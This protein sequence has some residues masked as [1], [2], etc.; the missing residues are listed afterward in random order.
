MTTKATA[1][2][3]GIGQVRDRIPA[4]G[5]IAVVRGGALGDLLFDVPALQA[6]ADAYPGAEIVLLGAPGPGQLLLTRPSPV[7]DFMPLPVSPG[8]YEPAGSAYDRK[9]EA[10]FFTVCRERAF[11]LVVQLHGGG[12]WSNPF[13]RRLGG[14]VAVGA[15]A[16]DA[17][18]LDRSVPYRALHH[19]VLRA[20]EVVGLVGAVPTMLEPSIAVTDEDGAAAV[21]ALGPHGHPLLTVH[22]G[23]T[24][25]RRRW[26]PE[27]FSVVAARAVRWGFDVAV[28]GSSGEGALVAEV[29]R[30]TRALLPTSD[31]SAVL[32]LAGSLDIR[33]LVGVLARSALLVGNDSGP[34]HLAQAVGTPTVA[35]FW[36]GNM[37]NAGPF[38][39]A[40]HRP[41]VSWTA[42]C[43]VCGADC[44]DVT[45]ERCA[46]DVSF[47]ADVEV[48]D[49]LSDVEDLL[50]H[51]LRMPSSPP[52]VADWGRGSYSALTG[53]GEAPA[54]PGIG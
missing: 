33:G 6:L 51:G 16:E 36:V 22:P 1:Y 23:A 41:H 53:D 37:I 54:M 50:G 25:P 10:E 52:A 47:V 24:D 27:R 29:A 49:V 28:V 4:V 5:R 46:D 40:L 32:E 38:G 11:D 8:V 7:D 19:E 14:R 42:R 44:T 35:V 26:P 17:E 34:R 31:R 13:V 45:A 21:T 20:L 18:P 30:E 39:R 15:C 9:A 3:H 43:P 12:R 2:G 48:S